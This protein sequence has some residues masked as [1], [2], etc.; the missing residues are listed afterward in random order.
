[1]IVTMAR[2]GTVLGDELYIKAARRA[3]DF[4]L[5]TPRREDGRL[6]QALS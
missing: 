3:V 1:M 6:P 5:G 2:A 4:V